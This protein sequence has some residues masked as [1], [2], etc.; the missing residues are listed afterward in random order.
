LAKSFEFTAKKGLK[1]EKQP[2]QS[3][4]CFPGC[5]LEVVCLVRRREY[6]K[7]AQVRK[8]LGGAPIFD[9]PDKEVGD[10][11]GIQTSVK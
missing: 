9:S 10:P 6:E 7:V 3:Q 8:I 11:V 5:V 1:K 2:W 4:R